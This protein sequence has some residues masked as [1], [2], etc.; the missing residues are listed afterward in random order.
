MA[1]ALADKVLG[2]LKTEED[3][4]AYEVLETFKGIDLEGKEY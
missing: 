3:E 2:Q 4:K 1:E